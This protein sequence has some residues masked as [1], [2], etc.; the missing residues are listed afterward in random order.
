M[1]GARR[2]TTRSTNADVHPGLRQVEINRQV[3]QDKRKRGPSESAGSDTPSE[4][5]EKR[6]VAVKK[7]A[8]MER[9]LMEEDNAQDTPKV[10]KP[11]AKRLRREHALS[12]IPAGDS[13]VEAPT[14][15]P[16]DITD[17]ESEPKMGRKPKKRPPGFREAVRDLAEDTDADNDEDTEEDVEETP[18]PEKS[19]SKSKPKPKA[20]ESVGPSLSPVFASLIRRA[21][22]LSP[23]TNR[24]HPRRRRRSKPPKRLSHLNLNPKRHQSRGSLRSKFK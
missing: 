19:K 2:V 8:A 3:A 22:S 24:C 1:T 6:A 14:P 7:I 12:N 15:R 18:K 9:D 11:R 4:A 17:E 20:R 21:H 23:T 5:E 13:E 16:K 10:A